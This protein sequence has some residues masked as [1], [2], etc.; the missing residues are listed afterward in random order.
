[1][2][3]NT[4]NAVRVAIGQIIIIVFGTLGAAT[5]EQWIAIAQ[6]KSTGIVYWATHYGVSLLL[7]PMVW[8]L[9]FLKV[10]RQRDLSDE[11]KKLVFLTGLILLGF[12]MI[13]F[14]A[15]SIVPWLEI[16]IDP[17]ERVDEL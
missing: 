16:R 9:I 1:M 4:K 10:Q 2:Q 14:L 7:L 3:I 13:F 12:L 6:K 11:V 5:S 17:L 15:S 8:T